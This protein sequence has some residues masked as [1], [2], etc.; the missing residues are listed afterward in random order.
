MM[1]IQ[2][3]PKEYIC[4]DASCRFPIRYYTTAEDLIGYVLKDRGVSDSPL[5]YQIAVIKSPFKGI[6]YQKYSLVLTFYFRTINKFLL[7]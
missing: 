1:Y 2:F 5:D 3:S 7:F 4:R 6:I